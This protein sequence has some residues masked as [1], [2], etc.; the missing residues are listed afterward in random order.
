MRGVAANI[1]IKGRIWSLTSLSCSQETQ[2]KYIDVYSM[3]Q[4][5]DVGFMTLIAR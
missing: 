4:I 1:K 2:N 3:V 5:I